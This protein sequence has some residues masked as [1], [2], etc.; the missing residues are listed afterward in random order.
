MSLEMGSCLLALVSLL[1]TA[2]IMLRARA[3][4]AA[5]VTLTGLAMLVGYAALA[6]V[7]SA[8]ALMRQPLSPTLRFTRGFVAGIGVGLVLAGV[9]VL[10]Y[11]MVT[12]SR[13]G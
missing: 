9:V 2:S 8:D 4:R 12:V 7:F 11:D 10:V 6:V 5:H 1:V 3:R 13:T